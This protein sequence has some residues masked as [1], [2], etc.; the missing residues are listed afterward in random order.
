MNHAADNQDL[1]HVNHRLVSCSTHNQP[2]WL[3]RPNARHRTWVPSL[4]VASFCSKKISHTWNAFNANK[5]SA[6]DMNV[7]G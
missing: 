1:D 4:C 6:K 7:R 5:S 2:R 3:H